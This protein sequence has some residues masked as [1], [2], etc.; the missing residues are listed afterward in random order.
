MPWHEQRGARTGAWGF[1]F[2]FGRIQLQP[3]GIIDLDGRGAGSN[4]GVS[5]LEKSNA[6]PESA[7]TVSTVVNNHGMRI[8]AA[9]E[10]RLEQWKAPD[11]TT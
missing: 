8:R 10:G 2:L 5:P 9:R 3:D 4:V 7:S 1:V 6:T 11:A